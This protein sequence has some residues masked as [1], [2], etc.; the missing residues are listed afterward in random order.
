MSVGS[1][2]HCLTLAIFTALCSGIGIAMIKH[3]L[4]TERLQLLTL[5]PGL[6]IYGIGIITGVILIGRYPLTVA[7]PVVVGLSLAILAAISALVLG[8]SLSVLKVAGTAL[9]L[10]GVVMLVRQP[11]NSTPSQN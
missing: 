8:E 10:V 7:Y 9:I 1:L 4:G 11:A 5:L 2:K 6:L 3:G